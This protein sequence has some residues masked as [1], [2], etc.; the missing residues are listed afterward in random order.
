M[1]IFSHQ[2]L[3]Y[4]FSVFLRL[5]CWGGISLATLLDKFFLEQILPIFGLTIFII[6]PTIHMT[7]IWKT[8]ND[9]TAVISSST[10]LLKFHLFKFAWSSRQHWN[11]LYKKCWNID[12]VER[13]Q[14]YD[15][16]RDGQRC[17]PRYTIFMSLAV[18]EC[19]RRART[20]AHTH[21]L[22][23]TRN[24]MKRCSYRGRVRWFTDHHICK[25]PRAIITPAH[26][27]APCCYSTC[28]K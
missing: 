7:F 16:D 6:A 12:A 19:S 8:F 4:G 21:T 14:K 10:Y 22:S 18:K 20:P 11:F 15:R 17:T 27:F 2:F 13:T 9:C 5:S 1:Y 3:K 28:V 24:M 25:L 23:H 26:K